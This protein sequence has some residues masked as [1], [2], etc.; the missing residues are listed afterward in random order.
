MNSKR[1]AKA[2]NS[3]DKTTLLKSDPDTDGFYKKAKQFVLKDYYSLNSESIRDELKQYDTVINDGRLL[4]EVKLRL[5]LDGIKK[6]P[7]DLS[8]GLVVLCE[9][10]LES[11]AVNQVYTINVGH[12]IDSAALIL[13]ARRYQLDVKDYHKFTGI[14]IK[15]RQIQAGVSVKYTLMIFRSGKINCLGVNN[16]GQEYLSLV[17]SNARKQIERL[18]SVFEEPKPD[19]KLVNCVLS[20]KIPLLINLQHLYLFNSLKDW[21]NIKYNN[22]LFPGVIVKIRGSRIR[23]NFFSTG[24]A[25]FT[26]IK[27]DECRVLAAEGFLELLNEYIKLYLALMDHQMELQFAAHKK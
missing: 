5:C 8:K 19:F 12:P 13:N 25:I 4:K 7:E 20:V 21:R 11:R 16:S 6:T 3:T 27:D 9:R 17:K 22:Q 1:E 2:R 23:I 10:I 18:V 24:S 26:G 15:I 14:R